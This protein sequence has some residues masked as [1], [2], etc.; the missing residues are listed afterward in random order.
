MY[1]GPNFDERLRE[2]VDV[3]AMIEEDNLK[4][5]DYAN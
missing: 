4:L 1:R 2:A 5:K 3:D